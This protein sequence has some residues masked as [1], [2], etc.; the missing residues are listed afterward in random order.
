V[1]YINLND[2][3]KAYNSAAQKYHGEFAQLNV[4]PKENLLNL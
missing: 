2:A 4:I 3:A 1:Y